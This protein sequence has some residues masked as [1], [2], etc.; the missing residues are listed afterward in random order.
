MLNNDVSMLSDD[1]IVNLGLTRALS[2]SIL[3]LFENLL[4][5]H[6]IYIPDDDRNGEDGEACLYGTTYGNLEDS[7]S[8]LL[9]AYIV[10]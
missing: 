1:L 10:D 4:D 8:A 6:G 5:K 2:V 9:A 3:D 7:I